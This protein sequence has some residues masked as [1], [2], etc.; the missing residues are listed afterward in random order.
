MKESTYSPEITSKLLKE[1]LVYK[2]AYNIFDKIDM[3]H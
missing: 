3:S 2:I 1:C